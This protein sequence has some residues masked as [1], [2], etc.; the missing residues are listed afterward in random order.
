MREFTRPGSAFGRIVY[1][2]K[3]RLSV[4]RRFIYIAH[5]DPRDR[6]RS[7]RNA[8]VEFAYDRWPGPISGLSHSSQDRPIGHQGRFL[9]FLGLIY[10]LA[11]IWLVI[12]SLRR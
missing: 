12:G 8:R 2:K 7:R 11:G 9:V 6:T 4:T 1:H 3:L 5:C 10:P